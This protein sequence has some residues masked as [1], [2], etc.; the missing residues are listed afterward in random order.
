MITTLI[1]ATVGSWALSAIVVL[2]LA[3]ARVRRADTRL[4][5]WTCVLTVSAALPL[6]GGAV[7]L[8]TW[9]SDAGTVAA[10]A[11][12]GSRVLNTPVRFAASA[13]APTGEIPWFLLAYASVSAVLLLR[14]GLGARLAAGLW[15]SAVPVDG[16]RFF[17]SARVRTPVTVGLVRPRIVLPLDWRSWSA[18]MLATVLTHEQGHVARRDGLRVAGARMFRA[19]CWM[20]PLA[21]WLPRHLTS[22]ADQASDEYAIEQ[23]IAAPDYAETLLRFAASP[24]SK[25][26]IAW[27]LPMATGSRSRIEARIDH[28]LCWK[29]T[30][31]M[32]VFSK[33]T[34]AAVLIVSGAILQ[35]TPGQEV[36]QAAAQPPDRSLT[37][38]Y[39]GAA[40]D[41]VRITGFGGTDDAPI[42]STVAV[43]NQTDRPVRALTFTVTR[44]QGTG[45]NPKPETVG[46]FRTEVA[47][48][49]HTL[50]TIDLA[51]SFS[52]STIATRFSGAPVLELSIAGVEYASAEV[53]TTQ[54]SRGTGPGQ[55][56]RAGAG[57]DQDRKEPVLLSLS[58]P[59]YTAEAM[60]QKIEGTVELE[61]DIDADGAV[62][63]ARVV[64]SLDTMY[65]LDDQAIA[66]AMKTT[67][68]PATEN[69]LAVGTTVKFQME[70]RLH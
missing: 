37:L 46:S 58:H 13:V 8:I 69:G 32:S 22:L 25:Q 4:F 23:G 29:G 10:V 30:P 31:P 33:V 57:Q 40:E 7:S 24:V 15:S 12:E 41:P 14:E 21:W 48:P 61:L 9:P 17:E 19:V 51:T 70:F 18:E 49:P 62:T 68:R 60:R 54:G 47:V 53:Q 38:V 11:A 36:Q 16:E 52:L 45:S 1:E 26:R 2:A 28:I 42:F 65:G 50:R 67:F 43:L 66:A 20:N 5:A 44:N 59:R 56:G 55:S 34:V 39:A 6:L 64:K 27:T 35:A 63:G 3:L